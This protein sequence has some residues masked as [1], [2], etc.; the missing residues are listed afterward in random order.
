VAAAA[1]AAFAFLAFVS[2]L[3]AASN[4]QRCQQCVTLCMFCFGVP[5]CASSSSCLQQACRMLLH[6]HHMRRGVLQHTTQHKSDNR[7]LPVDGC[8]KNGCYNNCT[9]YWHLSSS[10]CSSAIVRVLHAAIC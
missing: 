7:S 10:P 8:K 1:A 2:T 4:H 5:T 3:K 6:H 9:Q